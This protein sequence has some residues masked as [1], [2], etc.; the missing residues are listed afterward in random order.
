MAGE[1]VVGRLSTLYLAKLGPSTKNSPK[2]KV[3]NL[4]QSFIF[5]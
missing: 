2:N 1:W 5:H 3:K 4:F